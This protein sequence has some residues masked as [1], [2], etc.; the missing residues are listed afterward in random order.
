MAE[1]FERVYPAAVEKLVDLMLRVAA[2]D[3][4]ISHINR[5]RPSGPGYPHLHA[6]ERWVRGHLLQPG[7][8]IATELRLP[9]LHRNGGPVVAAAA[10][11]VSR[12]ADGARDDGESTIVQSSR[13]R[14]R[15]V[16][17]D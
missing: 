7:V 4:E 5:H 6:V 12:A 3:K 11:A 8:P 10:G 15:M 16:E 17:D 13:S 2:V 14:P 1:E 9:H